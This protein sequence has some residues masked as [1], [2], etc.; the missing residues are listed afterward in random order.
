MLKSIG[1]VVGCYALSIVLVL[2]CSPLLSVIFPGE[3]VSEGRV[4]PNA[5][6]RTADRVWEHIERH[7]AD[8][9]PDLCGSLLYDDRR[10]L[11]TERAVAS[12]A[13]PRP[14]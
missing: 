8:R 7:D 3:F 4:P 1:V 9:L 10:R 2:A 12:K 5:A 13:S 14:R 11:V 6:V